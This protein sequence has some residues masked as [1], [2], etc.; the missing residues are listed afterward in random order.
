MLWAR[1]I[2]ISQENANRLKTNELDGAHL[3]ALA[4]DTKNDIITFLIACG[5]SGAAARDI[6]LALP[7][8][9]P[10]ARPGS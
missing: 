7:S 3:A 1:Q 8:L 5:L 10:G 6:A 4:K 9:F 2:G